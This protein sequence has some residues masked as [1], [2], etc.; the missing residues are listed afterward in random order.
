MTGIHQNPDQY[1]YRHGGGP[2]EI[3]PPGSVVAEYSYTWRIR[4]FLWCGN[5][6]WTVQRHDP[7]PEAALAYGVR[8]ILNT[9]SSADRVREWLEG[10]T[11]AWHHWETAEEKSPDE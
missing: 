1:Q 4:C 8:R 10:Q 11:A 5:E 9:W 6:W 3:V 2:G 7:V